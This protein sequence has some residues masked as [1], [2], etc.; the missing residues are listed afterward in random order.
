LQIEQA[1]PGGPAGPKGGRVPQ[2][3][4]ATPFALLPG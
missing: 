4:E 1:G 3:Q 2:E